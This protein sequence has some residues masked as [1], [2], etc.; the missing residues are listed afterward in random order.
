M[1]NLQA[2]EAHRQS[3]LPHKI[4]EPASA[5]GFRRARVGERVGEGETSEW[6][7]YPLWSWTMIEQ[8]D[9]FGIGVSLY[10]R[11]LLAMTFIVGICA[12]ILTPSVNHNRR[13]CDHDAVR[14][15]F[16]NT[17]LSRGSAAGC[18]AD[19]LSVGQNV[20]PDIAVCV[21][22]LVAAI[23]ADYIRSVSTKRIDD[24]QQTPSDY[25]VM[26][27]NPPSHIV[28][29][30][31]YRDFFKNQFDDD[32][33][34]VTMSKDNGELMMLMATRAGYLQD[35]ADFDESLTNSRRQRNELGCIGKMLQPYLYSMGLFKTPDYARAELET[36]EAKLKEKIG[37][38]TGEDWHKPRSVF[39]TFATEAAMERALQTFEVSA[40]RRW[41]SNT[42]GWEFQDTPLA[43]EG[44]VLNVCRPVEPTEMQWHTS[45]VRLPE[46]VVRMFVS[47]AL[48]AA[49]IAC[50]VLAAT[51]MTGGALPAFVTIVNTL[52]P[53]LL[54]GISG[55]VE[56]HREYGDEQDSMF[57][58]LLGARVANTGIAAFV[59]F[60]AR[61]R[62]TKEALDQVMV[63]LILDAF[64]LP[65]IRALDPYDLFM[66]R[67]VGPQQPTQRAMNRFWSGAEWTIA[68]R[69]TD[70]AKTLFVGMFYA[71]AVPVGLWLT[72]ASMLVNFLVDHYC[73]LRLWGRKPDFDDQISRRF[74]GVVSII[75]LVHV[76]ATQSFF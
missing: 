49:L 35:L 43:F 71:A 22:I 51:Q 7:L 60:N 14:G 40:L 28:D 62:G 32:I 57:L 34:L 53:Q 27:R 38:N 44:R 26:I 13:N 52:L 58:K 9:S 31:K 36:V 67:V 2:A 65:L 3:H 47:F 76:V 19:D 39:V 37:E 17:G 42:T 20:G 24:N 56:I 41:F 33:V 73:L 75:V 72:A 66:R 59:S 68:E 61:E 46:R 18:F 21:I 74:I 1:P 63:I 55:M 50:F 30:D 25:T 69:Y 15:P 11:Q 5:L 10:F 16:R 12:A 8:L 23:L 4:P 54:K 45:H 70:V 64:F 29:P 48:T 6:H